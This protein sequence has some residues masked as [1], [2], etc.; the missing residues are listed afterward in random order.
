MND[1]GLL[2]RA[3]LERAFAAL[4]DR[5]VRRGVVADLFIV[6]GAA[7]ALAYDANRVTRDVDAT[8]VPHGVVLE[9]ARSVAEA[10]GLPPWWLNE[11]ASAYVSAEKDDGKREVFDHPGIR[12]M[13]ASPEHVFAMKA[14][15]ARSRDEEDLRT[16]AELI[17]ITT[18]N[19]AIDL[20][21]RFFPTEPLPPRSRAMLEDLF[22]QG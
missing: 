19:A 16:L 14:F 5:L 6:G 21:E 13:A 3:E 4:G 20:C 1:D 7:M 22:G 15:A 11:Q 8:F 12:V 9:E 18:T 2:G 10:M 17:G